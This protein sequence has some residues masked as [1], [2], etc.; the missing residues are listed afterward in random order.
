MG[1]RTGVPGGTLRRVPITPY[2]M[3]TTRFFAAKVS[4][5]LACV[6]VA[7]GAT[8]DDD[9]FRPFSLVSG[10]EQLTAVSA[11]VFSNYVRLRNPDGS[12]RAETYAFGN[13]GMVSSAQAGVDSA[14]I[15]ANGAPRG[16]GV[17]SDPTI[18][19]VSF[20]TLSRTI[21]HSLGEQNYIPTRDPNGTNLLIMVY[22]GRSSGSYLSTDGASNDSIDAWNA[23]LMGFDSD[24]FIR[25]RT[26][27][28]TAFFGRSLRS[29]IVDQVHSAEIS[30]LQMDRYYVVMRAFDFQAAW[31]Q[32]KIKLLWE[33]RFSLSERQHD[34]EKELPTMAHTASK[35]FGQD[36][37]GLVRA[38]IPEGQV[39]IG[40]VKSLGNVPS[41]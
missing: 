14:G 23:Q 15:I 10:S 12:Y 35:Y 39:D 3:K 11:R 20:G 8:S 38:R 29:M 4:F 30:A 9:L 1:L 17:V 32:R 5:L 26:D 37:D 2:L 7:A 28:S 16:G 33:T 40:N 34:F 27:V 6:A 36:T 25:E 18:D 22:W 41:N 31:R 13:G 21:A 24:R 19:D